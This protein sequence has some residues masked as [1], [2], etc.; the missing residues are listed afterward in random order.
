VASAA[1]L[2]FV[3]IIFLTSGITKPCQNSN[4]CYYQGRFSPA[5]GG[6]RLGKNQ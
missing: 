2:L 6:R 1:G 3:G 5:G 4:L